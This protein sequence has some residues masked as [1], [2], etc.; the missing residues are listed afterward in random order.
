MPPV[1]PTNGGAL[2]SS[3]CPR[4]RLRARARAQAPARPRLRA[5]ARLRGEPRP[6]PQP[7]ASA[8]ASASGSAA[9]S[10]VASS[11]SGAS[12]TSASSVG[13][14]RRG[15]HV[16]G[17]AQLGHVLEVG[18]G[19]RLALEH[20]ALDALDRQRQA[21][22]LGVDLEDLHLHL[23]ARLDD[24]ARVLDVLLGELAYVDEALDAL[25][26]LHERAERD[27]LRDRAL[28]LVTHVVGVDHTLPRILLGLLEAQGDALA[29]A[30]DVEH[31]D[32][33]GVADVEDLARVVD[34]RP[35]ELGDVDQAVDAVEVDERA[36]V[37]DVGDLALDDQARLEALQDRLALLLALLLEHR[38]A[39]E[40]HVVA[41]AVELYDLA[42]DVLA[43]VLVE[44]RHAP[45]VDERS[46]KEATH[47]EVDDQAAL[48]DLDH[49][50]DDRLAGLGGSLDAA[51]GALEAGAL[52]GQDQPAVLVLLGEDQRV[53]LLADL[54]LLR[55][56]DRLADR[57]LAGGDDALALVTDVDEDL[58]LV[59]P[60]HLAGDDVALLEGDDRGVVVGDDLTVDLEQQPVAALDDP[61]VGLGVGGR[62][63]RGFH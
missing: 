54:D 27:D 39:A 61:G 12:A 1:R 10:S 17:Q 42:L 63:H 60:H 3:R 40:H 23:V 57:Q 53:D 28:E 59:D 46:G 9:G 21:T 45:D 5:S 19:E 49:G 33:H 22:A 50:A 52:L 24:L 44:V 58:V 30:V 15:E 34:V 13:L 25:Q 56:V 6:R 51:P 18:V 62:G 41:R 43:Q 37:D 36:E 35:R 16:L 7:R 29:I 14:S 8:T 11:T 4:A 20:L 31:L 47:P 32:L 48:D 38:A 26:D 2:S 55:R